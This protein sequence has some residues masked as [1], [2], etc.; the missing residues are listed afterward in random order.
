[1]TTT[2]PAAAAPGRVRPLRRAPALAAGLVVGLVLLAVL[3]VVSVGVGARQV[4]P[5]DAWH[6]LTAFDP[7]SFDHAAVRSRVPRT[8]VALVVGAALGLAGTLMQGLTRN[9]LGDPGIL[10]INAGASAAVVLG[11]FVARVSDPRGYVWFAFV[12][13][14]AA[15]VV[16]HL[17]ASA[18]REGATPVKLALAGA[19]V[20]AALTSLVTAVLVTRT[21]ALDTFR[22]WQVG[23]VGGRDLSQVAELAPFLVVGAVLALASGRMLDA[24]ALGEDVARGLGQHVGRAR[25]IVGV[26]V[27]LLCGAAT[28]LAGPIAFVGL[29]VPHVGRA[30]TGPD[31]RWLLPYSA[32][33]GAALLV[34]SD[35]LGR[36]VAAPGQLEVG[37]VTAV[38]GAPVFV[39]LVRR[40]RL[41]EL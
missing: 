28:A 7:T 39:A 20:A 29:V 32:L 26:A 17:V 15:A 19:C 12:G 18:G 13:A 2:A 14:A 3:A 27:V 4:A 35:V 30:I 22:F 21:D 40:R 16:V 34:V 41:A 33:L 9:P 11:I 24:A 25:A 23:S 1:M 10:G 38:V 5:L 8:A 37:L 6:A 36:V 31:H